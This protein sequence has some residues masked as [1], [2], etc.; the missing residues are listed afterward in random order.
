M[1]QAGDVLEGRYQLESV[2]GSGGFGSV[3]HGRDLR[4]KR[5]VA[6]K[7]GLPETP[8]EVRRFIREAELAGGLS[9]PNI[10]TIHDVGQ[11]DWNGRALVY[12]VMELVRGDDLRSLLRRGLPDFRDSVLWARQICAALGA[13]HEAGIVHRDIKPANVIVTEAGT[14]KVLDFGI[15]KRQASDT[16]LTGEGVVIGSFPYMAPERWRGGAVDGR[17]DLYALGCLLME[18]WTGRLPFLGGTLHELLAQ[19]VAARP[20]VPSSFAPGLPHGADQLVLDLLAKDPSHRPPHARE[21]ARRLALLAEPSRATAAPTRVQDTPRGQDTPQGHG[22]PAQGR[23]GRPPGAAV[24]SPEP[25]APPQGRAAPP[26]SYSPTVADPATD[27]LRAALRRR[28]DQIQALPPDSDVTEYLEL[29]DALIPEAQRELG[30]DDPLT[31]DALLSRARRAWQRDPADTGL[32]RLLP[33]L[34]RVFGPEDRRTIDARAAL[35]GYRAFLG[36]DHPREALPELADVIE[37]AARVLGPYDTVTLHARAQSALGQCRRFGQGGAELPLSEATLPAEAERR[38]AILEPVLAD[39]GRGLPEHDPLRWEVHRLAASDAYLMED[40][41]RAARLYDELLP[42][43]RAVLGT[44]P[45]PEVALRHARSVGEAGE[46][47][48][49]VTM[50]A[51]LNTRLRALPGPTSPLVDVVH[52]LQS[53]YRRRA[54]RQS[55]ESRSWFRLR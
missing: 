26:P 34:H 2:L 55:G 35:L 4:M 41:P 25:A 52:Q 38:R 20:P 1:A 33:K 16:D 31:T 22:T 6:V 17:A 21:V 48:R 53:R 15:A 10:T 37:L 30:P 23:A 11:V 28:L 51:E 49:A 8:R 19:H 14:V 54:R 5:A 36:A 27:P 9:Q 42:L 3:W 46:P 29:L 50:L 43:N 47:G 13:A 32:S 39:L 45:A 18:L 7:T 12:I 40:Y 44:D 24:P